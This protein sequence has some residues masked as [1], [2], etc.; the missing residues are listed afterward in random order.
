MQ[1]LEAASSSSEGEEDA[2]QRQ[3]SDTEGD[4]RLPAC[5]SVLAVCVTL[6]GVADHCSAKTFGCLALMGAQPGNKCSWQ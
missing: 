3:G 1:A 6:P 4:G 2:S 5:M